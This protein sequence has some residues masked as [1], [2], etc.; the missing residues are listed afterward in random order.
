MASKKELIFHF[1][2]F[3]KW[4]IY[5]VREDTKPVHLYNNMVELNCWY[6]FFNQVG[7]DKNVPTGAV[8]PNLSISCDVDFS[9]IGVKDLPRYREQFREIY[10]SAYIEFFVFFQ[11]FYYTDNAFPM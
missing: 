11:H 10:L 1:K 3:P 4:I 7:T 6:T 8:T 9:G 5:N 2:I